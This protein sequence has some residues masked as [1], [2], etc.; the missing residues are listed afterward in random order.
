[1]AVTNLAEL[2]ELVA[3]VKA[4]QRVF[5][6]SQTVGKFSALLPWLPTMPVFRRWLEWP[7][8]IAV[9]IEDKV[10]KSRFVSGRMQHS[11]GQAASILSERRVRY[12]HHR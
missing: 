11:T 4:A 3:R 2:D 1:M 8:R 10:I 6:A 9:V 7:L 12:R 5:A